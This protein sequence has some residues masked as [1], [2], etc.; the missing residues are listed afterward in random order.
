[1]DYESIL[2]GIKYSISG[3]NYHELLTICSKYD[4]DVSCRKISRHYEM[5]LLRLL[6][7]EFSFLYCFDVFMFFF[8]LYVCI[9]LCSCLCDVIIKKTIISL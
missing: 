4:I 8:I 9:A 7:S 3:V 6:I 2:T 5:Y 1:M